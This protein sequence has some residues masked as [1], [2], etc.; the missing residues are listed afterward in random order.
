MQDSRDLLRRLHEI[1][2][3]PLPE[4]AP[5]RTPGNDL[6][7]KFMFRDLQPGT[8]EWARIHIPPGAEYIERW[9]ATG[10]EDFG[11]V[12]ILDKQGRHVRRVER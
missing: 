10:P 5:V 1:Y 7:L 9:D 4:G 12:E 6:G 11:P 3:S 8:A 2:H